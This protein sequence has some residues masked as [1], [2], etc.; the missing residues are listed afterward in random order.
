MIYGHDKYIKY[1]ED[2]IKNNRF[3]NGYIFHGIGGIGKKKFAIEV[4]R[5]ALCQNNSSFNEDCSCGSC[6]LIK[7]GVHPDLIEVLPYK[8]RKS[9]GID[10]IR[11]IT[12][13]VYFSSFMGCYKF[14]ILDNFHEMS[15]EGCNAFLKTLEEPGENVVFFIITD[16][17]NR[18]IPT[19]KSRCLQL[20]FGRLKNDDML[21]ILT[22]LGFDAEEIKLVLEFSGGSVSIAMQ[23]LNSNLKDQKELF[24]NS[25]GFGDILIHCS[26]I[27]KLSEK[28]ELRYY[29]MFIIKKS[30]EM[31][32]LTNRYSYL[33]FIN[34]ILDCYRMLD[35]NINIRILRANILTKIYGVV[36]EKV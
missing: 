2:I 17:I 28:E 25:D 20:R 33:V 14:Y 12:D 10:N 9:I 34:Q 5:V 22:S 15:I 32:R 31:Y 4:S 36:G 29:M 26:N 21:K 6:N 1:F 18:I 7:K 35:Y 23:H 3:V 30:L 11:E 16:N 13:T 27:L 19:I 24:F 8:D